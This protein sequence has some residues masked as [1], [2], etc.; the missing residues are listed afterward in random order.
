MQIFLGI[1][2]LILV[3]HLIFGD[4]P[5]EDGIVKRER[6][7]ENI[8][9]VDLWISYGYW[10]AAVNTVIFAGA[11]YTVRRWFDRHPAPLREALAPPA[12]PPRWALALAG[13]AVVAG[14]GIAVPRMNQS[15][16]DDEVYSVKK[17]VWGGY[18]HDYKGELK[19]RKVRLRD[20]FWYY[21]KPNNQVPHSIL[22]RAS[23]SVWEI[24]T[25]PPLRFVSEWAL[26]IPALLAGGGSIAAVAW[27]AW[28][29]G[30]TGAGVLAAWILA[31]HPWH[32][33][34][35]SE[36]RGYSIAMC[37]VT[38]TVVLLIRALHHGT[39]RRWIAY[40]AVQ[41]LLLWTYPAILYH[42]V[43]LN[44]I[45]V[46]FLWRSDEG[47]LLRSQMTRWFFVNALGALAWVQVMTP[48]MVQFAEYEKSIRGIGGVS[49]RW[50]QD[51][52]AHLVAGMQYRPPKGVVGE[53]F[54]PAL[55]QAAPAL[56]VG[57]VTLAVA[58]LC[59]GV[60]RLARCGGL[61]ARLL[62]VF[63][64][65]GPLL[66]LQSLLRDD[67]LYVWY[68]IFVLP[69]LALLISIGLTT[70][71]TENGRRFLHGAAIA[72]FVGMLLFLAEPSHRIQW[73]RSFYPLRESVELTRE[74][75]DPFS[76]TNKGIVTVGWVSAPTYYDPLNQEIETPKELNRLVRRARKGKIELYVNLG[77]IRM[78]R[79]RYPEMTRR[80]EE[81]GEF[82]R[83]ALVPGF[84]EDRTRHVWRYAQ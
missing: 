82:E 30:F 57:F 66:V 73:E 25:D 52:A 50:F 48:N 10:V 39:W 45:A 55:H 21:R 77:R 33:R 83:V 6:R 38:V 58:A 35:L 20:T 8:R 70:A 9:P 31:L 62:A 59:V 29:M 26:R 63:L 74:D 72:G 79:K 71:A 37:L 12:R 34:Y 2:L 15:L 54:Y 64:L 65:P 61:N 27:L 75:R 51:F 22:A 53:V 60:F 4:H 84:T 7:G 46:A 28:R 5:W 32:S 23:L 69:P 68:V 76:K 40:G 13:L 14:I 17:A 43:V 47:V 81:G 44:L 36:A 67:H 41:F 49:G 1:M 18:I 19:L 56:L 42:L 16:W 11:L 80:V 78:A 24:F 3:I